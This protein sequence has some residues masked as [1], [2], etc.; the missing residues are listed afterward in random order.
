MPLA[1][2]QAG[3]TAEDRAILQELRP[4]GKPALRQSAPP[5]LLLVLNK[6]DRAPDAHSS[7]SRGGTPALNGSGGAPLLHEHWSA[8]SAAPEQTT[9]AAGGEPQEPPRVSPAAEGSSAPGAD[10]DGVLRSLLAQGFT[11]QQLQRYCVT[12][13]AM[14]AAVDSASEELAGVNDVVL[15]SAVTGEGLA[16][17]KA[18]VLALTGSPDVTAGAGVRWWLAHSI[19]QHSTAVS[20]NYCA[21]R[22]RGDHCP[23]SR[24]LYSDQL[25]V[26]LSP[27]LQISIVGRLRRWSAVGSE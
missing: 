24:R 4:P 27:Y 12:S 8:P 11:P 18:A 20:Y 2:L 5:P 13:A 23:A 26:F 9:E 17:L 14:Q 21:T 15:T 7:A 16:D 10:I 22:R 6:R 3:W 25:S 19:S 1:P